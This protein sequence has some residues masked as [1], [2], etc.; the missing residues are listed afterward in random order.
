MGASKWDRDPGADW[1]IA[2]LPSGERAMTDSPLGNYDSA[3]APDVALTTSITSTAFS[4]LEC[5]NPVLNFRHDYVIAKVGESQDTG[6]VEISTDAGATWTTLA[7][8][9][10][11]GIYD[12]RAVQDQAAPEWSVVNW[13]DVSISPPGL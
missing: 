1:E 5:S 8:Y 2:I 11:G 7:Q 4:L 13:Q 12:G 3:I 6:R 10:G 9:S